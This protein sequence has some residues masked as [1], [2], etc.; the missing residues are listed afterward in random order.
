MITYHIKKMLVILMITSISVGCYKL[1]RAPYDKLNSAGFW[2]TDEHAKMGIM[3]VYA[4][5]KDDLVYGIYFGADC[6]SD[7]GVGYDYASLFSVTSGTYTTRD[8]YVVSKWVG[9]YDGVMRANNAIKKLSESNTINETVKKQVIGEARF[10]RAL[11]YFNLLDYYGGV[12]LYDESVD[13]E[14]DYN[15][16]LKPRS[17]AEETRAFILK[18]LNEAIEALPISWPTEDYGRAT[19]GAAIALRGKTYLYAQKY[20]LAEADFQEIVNNSA[21]YGYALHPNYPDLF[22][23]VGHKSS[24]MIFAIQNM[25]G[26]GTNY[27]MP[28]GWYM[29]TRSSFGSCWNNVMVSTSLADRYEC[30]DGKPF[31]WNDY[32][33]GFN[34]SNTVKAET[35]VAKLSGDAKS[36]S[37]LPKHYDKLLKMYENRDP[38]MA[39]TLIL[40]YSYYNGWVANNLRVCRFVPATGANEAGGFIRN[41]KGWNTY[42]F[43]KFV[44][45]ANMGGLMT[46]RAHTP[47]NFPIIRYADVLLMLAECKNELGDIHEAI[48]YINQV[49]QRPS[50]NLP[51]INSGPA[52]L[53]ATT[54]Q[55]VFARINQER[56]VELVG[57]GLRFSDLRRWKIAEEVL[58]NRQE[59]QF[60]GGNPLFTRK[61][62]SKDYLWPIP[63]TEIEMNPALD[64]NPGWK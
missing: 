2:Q 51:A 44:P 31:N 15:N 23:P 9:C 59:F 4:Q 38:R 49:R 5:L 35:F 10:L 7:I 6:I 8:R 58:N 33:A 39:Q 43:R 21:K 52:W 37:E 25:G 48:R 40:P 54:K 12:P 32:I 16:L 34:E 63:A 41:N 1:D 19:K 17:T 3:A 55:E 27:G 24:E 11:Y 22:T 64:Q 57:E 26:V 13:L 28:M 47:I 20:A 30:K 45:E 62:E 42:F 60:T 36:V 53:K 18:D 50:T 14:R 29:G 46:N 56:A 61:F